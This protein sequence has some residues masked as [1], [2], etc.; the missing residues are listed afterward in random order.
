MN[1]LLESSPSSPAE[2]APSSAPRYEDVQLLTA[3]IRQALAPEDRLSADQARVLR[4][5]DE[6]GQDSEAELMKETGFGKHKMSLIVGELRTRRLVKVLLDEKDR[7]KHIVKIK[8][9]GTALLQRLDHLTAEQLA[10]TTD[11]PRNPP[12]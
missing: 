9:K 8:S 4:L 11:P 12:L 10:K 3:S 7:R 6:R 2:P 5:V 1:S